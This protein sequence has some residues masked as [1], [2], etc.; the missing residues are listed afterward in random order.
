MERKERAPIYELIA[1]LHS[2]GQRVD[3]NSSF[4]Y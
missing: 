1:A 2:K 3:K 4:E